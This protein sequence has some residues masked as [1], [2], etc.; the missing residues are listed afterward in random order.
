MCYTENM[1]SQ[2]AHLT[3]PGVEPGNALT[4]EQA[5]QALLGRDY[6]AAE[7]LAEESLDRHIAAG[8]ARDRDAVSP[9]EEE[10]PIDW[11]PQLSPRHR[12]RCI[13]MAMLM[14]RS[15]PV[16]AMGRQFG[17]G[18]E[19]INKYVNEPF[20]QEL[21]ALECRKIVDT[22]RMELTQFRPLLYAAIAHLLEKKHPGTVH[23]MME[24]EGLVKSRAAVQI[25][26]TQVN[27]PQTADQM[28]LRL[29]ELTP[30]E[31]ER[32]DQSIIDA[33]VV[34]IRDEIGDGIGDNNG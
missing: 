10:Y 9:L 11:P 27:V 34:E 1:A 25:T 7:S 28:G 30:E 12:L 21:L 5:V 19:A 17:I 18:V 24:V 31:K 15:Y 32:I 16:A 29:A 13:H 33:E 23:K 14:S 26:N 3:K 20:F 6:E 4:E 2:I 22:D 8:I